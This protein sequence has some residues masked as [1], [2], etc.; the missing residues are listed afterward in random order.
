MTRGCYSIRL[1]LSFCNLHKKKEVR[2]TYKW[3][4]NMLA[5]RVWNTCSVWW[6]TGARMHSEERR[7]HTAVLAVVDSMHTAMKGKELS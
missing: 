1:M 4:N 2:V 3:R 5:T 6:G 7:H